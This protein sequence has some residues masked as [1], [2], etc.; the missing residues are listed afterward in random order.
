M[1]IT[2]AAFCYSTL[3]VGHLLILSALEMELLITYLL[4]YLLTYQI[5]ISDG[6][7]K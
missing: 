1:L 6:E 5:E 3:Y 2:P 7:V 4:I